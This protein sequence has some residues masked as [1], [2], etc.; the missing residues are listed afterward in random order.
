MF[1]ALEKARWQ[2]YNSHIVL[3]RRAKKRFQI[4]S[5]HIVAKKGLVFIRL[6]LLCTRDDSLPL[7]NSHGLFASVN[8]EKKKCSCASGHISRYVNPLIETFKRRAVLASDNYSDIIER[9]HS[10][11]FPPKANASVVDPLDLYYTQIYN[12]VYKIWKILK[13]KKIKNQKF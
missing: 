7:R 4:S 1:G 6:S 5:V 13:I 10:I 2:E 8:W 3:R 11:I 12:S 9:L